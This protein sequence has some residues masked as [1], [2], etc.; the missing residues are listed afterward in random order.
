MDFPFFWDENVEQGDINALLDEA[1][2]PESAPENDASLSVKAE[3]TLAD[4]TESRNPETQPVLEDSPNHRAKRARS[5]L[6]ETKLSSDEDHIKIARDIQRSQKKPVY[7]GYFKIEQLEKSFSIH[8]YL[9]NCQVN[10][11][12]PLPYNVIAIAKVPIDG[13]LDLPTLYARCRCVELALTSP[14]GLR[15]TITEPRAMTAFINGN[16]TIRL[17][18]PPSVLAAKLAMQRVMKIIR[19]VFN[20]RFT[21]FPFSCCNILAN[22]DYGTPVRISEFAKAYPNACY[23]EPL[24]FCGV[25]VSFDNGVR[26]LV[27]V[28]G[29]CSLSG[30]R[31]NRDLI[32]AYQTLTRKVAPFFREVN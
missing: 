32:L 6:K 8:D 25:V 1:T 11:I 5:G 17:V 12:V 21:D 7:G 13:P 27:F 20:M 15:M 4:S 3:S 31:S 9:P 2:R 22:F 24:L 30:A 10:E 14:P 29:K 26:A 28:S 16:K 19:E 23:Y 18:G